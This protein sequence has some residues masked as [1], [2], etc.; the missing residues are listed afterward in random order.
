MAIWADLGSVQP[1]LY[2]GALLGVG[3]PCD[4]GVKQAADSID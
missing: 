4:L 1:C 2:D 3:L